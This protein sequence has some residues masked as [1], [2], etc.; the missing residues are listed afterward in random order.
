MS[1][2]LNTDIATEVN[3][4]KHGSIL[5]C[6]ASG[7]SIKGSYYRSGWISNEISR[8]NKNSSIKAG[9]GGRKKEMRKE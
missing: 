2:I 1:V 6:G 8:N 3:L 9:G 4:V 5:A 7:K